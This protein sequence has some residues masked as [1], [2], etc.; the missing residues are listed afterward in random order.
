M[1]L[2]I[3]WALAIGVFVLLVG[4]SFS[5]YVVF[6]NQAS[7]PVAMALDSIHGKIMDSLEVDSYDVIVRYNISAPQV[8]AIL[9][10][11]LTWPDESQNS[12]QI[13]LGVTK[14]N[15]LTC[16]ITD[17]IIYWNHSLVAGDNYF[18][19]HFS[20]ISMNLNCTSTKA[21]VDIYSAGQNHTTAWVMEKRKI[22]SQAHIDRFDSKKSSHMDY[23][24][25]RA[26][27]GIERSFRLVIKNTTSNVTYGANLPLSTNV[28]V[29]EVISIV[30]ETNEKIKISLSVW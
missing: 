25:Y 5:F 22:V 30:E 16:N 1:N 29:K 11:N 10:L 28:F 14:G 12:T 18:L 7:Q 26:S 19:V 3:D 4:W 6:F 13:H 9:N 2:S 20:N 8:N 27:K 24:S 23:Q 21:Q 15:N 17:G